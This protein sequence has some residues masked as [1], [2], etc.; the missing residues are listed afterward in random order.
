MHLLSVAQIREADRLTIEGGLVPGPELMERA[1]RGAFEI[2][3]RRFGGR[4]EGRRVVLLCGKGN[5]GGDGFVIARHLVE[6]GA[7]ATLFLLA[8]PDQLGGDARQAFEGLLPLRPS[9]FPLVDEAALRL[10]A[11]HLESCDLAVDALFGTGIKGGLRG[12]GLDAVRLLN[13]HASR[14]LSVDV[15]SGLSGDAGASPGECVRADLTVCMAA[16]KAG[17]FE[18]PG[19]G[20]AGE[21]LTVDIG[22]P[23]RVMERVADDRRLVDAERAHEFLPAYDPASHKYRRGSLLVVAGSR[24][25]GGAALLT[26]G[27]ALRS[28]VGMAYVALPASLAPL[29]QQ[30]HPSAICLALPETADGSL[31]PEAFRALS[32]ELPRVSALAIGPGLGREEATLASLRDFLAPVAAPCLLDADALFAYAD[33]LDELRAHAGPRALT[34]HSGELAALLGEAETPG[35]EALET[36]AG[37]NLILLSKGAP[38]RVKGAGPEIFTLGAGH[39]SMARGG[40]GDI[41]SGLAGGL[42]AQDIEPLGAILLAGYLH[43]EAGRLAGESLGRSAHSTDLLDFLP[44]AWRRVEDPLADRGLWS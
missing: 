34:P 15:P 41:L 21:V 43:G 13:R 19:A 24:R 3:R 39:P 12:R 2:I 33:R 27:G 5:N 6:E 38:T 42:L 25:Y 18:H 8:P 4:L 26:V 28:G 30:R 44:A 16:P 23:A 9:I 14:V 11:R 35:E 40:T 22:I 37:G 10:C 17:L 32:D 20:A 7:S 1:G 36:V 29:V 31:A